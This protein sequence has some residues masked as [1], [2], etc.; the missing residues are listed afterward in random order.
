MRADQ[1]L[2][3]GRLFDQYL[4]QASS[5]GLALERTALRSESLHMRELLSYAAVYGNLSFSEL[6]T[7]LLSNRLSAYSV[8]PLPW[9]DWHMRSRSILCSQT[10]SHSR[11][12]RSSS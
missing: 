6:K 12:G 5:Q 9:E 7:C 11:P 10:I 2:L 1:Y 3:R 8:D 4:K